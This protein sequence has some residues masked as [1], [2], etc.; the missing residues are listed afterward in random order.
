M[1]KVV[2]AGNIETTEMNHQDGD[3]S[4]DDIDFQALHAETGLSPTERKDYK[5]VPKRKAW[6][7]K[8]LYIYNYFTRAKS[9]AGESY[10]PM[11]NEATWPVL[12]T[13]PL[14][15]ILKLVST[16]RPTVTEYTLRG[17]REAIS[18]SLGAST[19]GELMDLADTAGTLVGEK[20]KI[21]SNLGSQTSSNGG[22]TSH[23]CGLE[24]TSTCHQ[25]DKGLDDLIL[26]NK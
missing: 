20:R 24:E 13:G 22:P 8:K 6:N 14:N 16:P 7:A 18:S 23:D 3:I 11:A 5:S 12:L 2:P 9:G 26:N 4:V 10:N 15:L 21:H 17:I 19:I 1:I 25:L